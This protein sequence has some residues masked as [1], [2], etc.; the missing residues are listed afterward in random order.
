MRVIINA[1]KKLNERGYCD[2]NSVS[3]TG[4]CSGCDSQV[5]HPDFAKVTELENEDD[6]DT[7]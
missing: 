2:C 6:T 5:C 1:T 7:E 3:G 4:P